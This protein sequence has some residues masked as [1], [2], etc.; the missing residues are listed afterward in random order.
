MTEIRTRH[1][2]WSEPVLPAVA[3]ALADEH[4]GPDELDLGHLLLAFPG[5]RPSRRTTEL[6]VAEAEERGVVLVPPRTVTVGALPELLYRPE[7]SLADRV[8]RQRLWARVLRETPAARLEPVVPDPPDPDDLAGWAALA[9]QIRTVHREVAREELD[10]GRV[11]AACAEGGLS[12]DDSARWRVLAGLQERYR[13]ALDAAGRTDAHRARRRALERDSLGLY[14]LYQY[15]EYKSNKVYKPAVHLVGVPE[16]PGVLKRMLRR[17]ADGGTP[18]VAWI[19]APADRAG[20]F[21]ELGCVVPAEWREARVPVDDDDLAFRGGPAEQADEALR[22]VAELS[23]GRAAEE[24]TVGVPHE[25]LTPWLEQRFEAHGVPHRVAAGTPLSRTAPFRLLA[26]CADYLDGRAFPDLAALLRHPDL[27]A[28]AGGDAGPE[29]ADAYFSRHL[30]ARITD[31]LTSRRWPP[32]ARNPRARMAGLVEKVEGAGLLEPLRGPPRHLTR[33]MPE[34]LGLLERV[35]GAEP[36]DRSRPAQRRI[37]EACRAVRDRAADFHA[38]PDAADEV[39]G[40]GA[41]IRLLLA[42]LRGPEDAVPPEPEEAAVEVLGWLELHLDDAPDLVLTGANEPHLPESVGAD[43]FLPNRLRQ[44]LGL[45]DDEARFARDA[46]LLTAVLRARERVRIVAGRRDAEGTPLRP[47]RL[48]LTGDPEGVARRLL[49]FLEAEGVG[50]EDADSDGERARGFREAAPLGLEPADRPGFQ[51]PPRDRLALPAAPERMRVT[52]F[53]SLMADPYR[54]MLER[55][56]GLDELHDED[57]ELDPA[58]FGSLAH[59]VLEGFGRHDELHAADPDAV[60]RRLEA[61]LDRLAD[62]GF[63]AS[64]PAVRVQVEQLRARLRAFARWHAARVAEG[65]RVAAT[66]AEVSEGVPF[67]V[68]GT[69]V[70]LLGRIDRVDVHA[71]RGLVAVFDYKTGS[72]ADDPARAHRSRAGEWKDL[73]L[74]L[75]RHFLSRLEDADGRPLLPDLEAMEVRLGYVH[76]PKDTGRV[77]AAFLEWDDALLAEADE[78]ARRWI[79]WLRERDAVEFDPDRTRT[80]RWDPL[81]PLLG[82]GVLARLGADDVDGEDDG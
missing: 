28:A 4:A 67:D 24:V 34:I 70:R 80:H 47:S 49:R 26:A 72:R 5:G 44:E 52:E 36:L 54:W 82:R 57:R 68:D 75:Y 7:R 58:R 20:A 76:L 63:P 32:D 66:E 48:L 9:R 77:G 38:L 53:R 55:R 62:E 22:A 21:D 37:L 11:A 59:R 3:R 8:L 10:F 79:R 23:D 30:P 78:E 2:D 74:P 42:E 39:C 81:G 73:Q 41:A 43:L 46:Y 17:L 13:E 25:G 18:V 6:L 64:L 35:Y 12:F 60:G 1:V 27:T 15:N 69:P 16:M 40:A 51:V 56:L 50:A 14:H 33:W 29:T 19:H 71:D 31:R 45:P 65:W 61:V